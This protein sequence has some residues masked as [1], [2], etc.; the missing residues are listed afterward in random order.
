[1]KATGW[2]VYGWN[3]SRLARSKTKSAT[4]KLAILATWMVRRLVIEQH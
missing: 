3:N 4:C 2:S 1:M